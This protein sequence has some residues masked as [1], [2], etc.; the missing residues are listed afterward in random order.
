MRL[1]IALPLTRQVEDE[2]GRLKILLEQKGGQVKWVAPKNIHLTVRFLGDTDERLVPQ[3]IEKM[4]AVSARFQPVDT[5]IDGLGGFPTISRPRVIWV[6]IG[7]EVET[8]SELAAQME[9]GMQ[10]LGFEREK[11]GFKSHLTLGRVRRP[12]GLDQLVDFLKEYRLEPIPIQF[13]R[14]CLFKS[15]LTPSG[16]IY[17]R[18]HE[19]ALGG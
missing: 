9:R 17:E 11:K 6:G 13:D 7:R 4:D 16:P 1:F 19:A 14:L 2:L 15:T 5:V 8:L 12:Q 3:I 10:Q 18:L